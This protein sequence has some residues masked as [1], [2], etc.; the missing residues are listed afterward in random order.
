VLSRVPLGFDSIAECRRKPALIHGKELLPTRCD[1]MA[2]CGRVVGHWEVDFDQ[3]MCQP[4]WGR[5]ND[6]GCDP[7][8]SGKRRWEAHLDNLHP[9]DN[10]KV[11]CETTPVDIGGISFIGAESCGDWG[12]NGIWGVWFVPDAT[13]WPM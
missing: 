7:N 6:K 8:H 10:W 1:D 4:W 12:V 2:F 3:G 13:C 11:M 9:G 5:R